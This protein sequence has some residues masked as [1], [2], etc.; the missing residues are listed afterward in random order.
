MASELKNNK[1]FTLVEFLVAM[2]ILIVGMLGLLTSVNYALAHNMVSQLRNEA[3]N[4]ADIELAGQMAKGFDNVSTSYAA[5]TK[6]SQV[7]GMNSFKNYSIVRNP[8]NQGSAVEKYQVFSE[9]ATIPT[10][11]I[12]EYC[13][14]WKYGKTRY[15]HNA[16]SSFSRKNK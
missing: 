12:V 14:S 15:Q 7:Q 4:V 5:Y 10:T 16:S 3:V 11:K 2:V 6:N 9:S 1:G 13:I 8:L